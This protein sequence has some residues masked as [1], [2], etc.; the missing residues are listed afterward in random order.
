[1]T[2]LQP[3]SGLG[4]LVGHLNAVSFIQSAGG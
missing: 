2:A 1:M 4:R 3:A